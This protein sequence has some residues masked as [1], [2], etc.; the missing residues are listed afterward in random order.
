MRANRVFGW[1]V[2]A[3]ALA[4]LPGCGK[5][6]P[7]G[8]KLIPQSYGPPFGA[9]VERNQKPH[10]HQPGSSERHSAADTDKNKTYA[11]HALCRAALTAAVQPHPDGK[12]VTL[13]SMEAIGYYDKGA[14]V[15]EHRCTDYTLSHRAWCKFGAEEG[16]HGEAHGEEHG[17]GDGKEHRKLKVKCKAKEGVGH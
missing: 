17:A 11:S 2:A 16:G 12:I 13:S 4:V 7:A 6:F 10:P 3:A 1:A 5:N 15:H 8:E 9:E 14:E